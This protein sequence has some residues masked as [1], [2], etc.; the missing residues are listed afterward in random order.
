MIYHAKS[1]T[2]SNGLFALTQNGVVFCPL[3]QELVI[4]VL[5]MAVNSKNFENIAV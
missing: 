1:T 2:V 5:V 4:S 3:F